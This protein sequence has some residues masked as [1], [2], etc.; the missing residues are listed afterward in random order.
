MGWNS[1]W[2]DEKVSDFIAEH[3]FIIINKS[4]QINNFPHYLKYVELKRLLYK[5]GER[6]NSNNYQSVYLLPSFFSFW[7]KSYSK[8]VSFL[9]TNNI[10][11]NQQFGF[12]KSALKGSGWVT[13]HSGWVFL[14][15]PR[16][17]TVSTMLFSSKG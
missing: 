4:F 1:C 16:L 7:K 13:K 17:L 5:K 6:Q 8:L 3:L 14:I 11:T 2:S 15:S 10:F 12:I 9:E